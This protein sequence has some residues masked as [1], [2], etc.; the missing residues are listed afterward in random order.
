M[1]KEELVIDESNFSEY[2]FDVRYNQPKK[3]QVM[4]C[5]ETMAEFMDSDMKREIIRQLLE[6]DNGGNST[7]NI[8]QKAGNLSE[9]EAVRVIKEITEDLLHGMTID[10]VARK[11]YIFPVRYFFYTEIQNIPTNDRHWSSIALVDVKEEFTDEDIDKL[12][13]EKS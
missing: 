5:Y 11:P 6:F 1:E 9:K 8:M 12:F 2:F 7:V 13:A 3:G 10:E 4:A